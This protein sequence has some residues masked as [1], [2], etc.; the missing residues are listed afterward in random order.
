MTPRCPTVGD[1]PGFV[2]TLWSNDAKRVALADAA[3][4]DRIGL[5]LETLGK[6][7]RQLGKATWLSPHRLDDLQRISPHIR[8]ASL[9]VRTDP[10]NQDSDQQVLALIE[11]GVKVLMLPNFQHLDEVARYCDLVAGRAQVVPLVERVAAIDCIRH[12]P[13]L[14]IEEIH[15]GLNDLSFDLRLP[16]RMGALVAPAIDEIFTRARDAGLQVGVGGLA[17]PM[18]EH[19]PIPADL[20]Y[21]EQAR[22][23]S[24]GAILARSF[25]NG[26]GSDTSVVDHI[27]QLRIRIDYWRQAPI[28]EIEA[29]HQKLCTRLS[30][31]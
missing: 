29:A 31:G 13:S 7:T 24:Q 3:G 19:L 1:T 20:V 22:L 16:H 26:A 21:A 4:V 27:G 18:D 6:S 17:R 5:D 15:V 10:L 28:A 8:N 9:F 25:F 12:L 11:Q 30:T 23:G 2:L 14:G